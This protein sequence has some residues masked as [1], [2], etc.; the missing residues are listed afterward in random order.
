DWELTA[1]IIQ[2][3]GVEVDFQ[4]VVAEFQRLYRGADW[5]GLIRSETPLIDFTDLRVLTA[6]GLDLGIVTGRPEAEAHWTIDHFGWSDAFPVVIAREQQHDR[7]KP[8]GFPLRAALSQFASPHE[9]A[10]TVYLGDTVDDVSAALNAGAVPVGFV[11]PYLDGTSH[12]NLL[13]EHGARTVISTYDELPAVL[14]ITI[15]G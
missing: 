2:D 12:A 8:D 14:G 13:R 15:A 10:K 1:A 11:P 4:D 6:A 3:A 5:D 9:P 7:P